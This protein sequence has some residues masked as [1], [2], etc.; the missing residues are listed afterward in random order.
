MVC[1]IK[2]LLLF[3]YL[4]L[5]A[6]LDK[7]EVPNIQNKP[8]GQKSQKHSI[9]DKNPLRSTTATSGHEKFGHEGELTKNTKVYISYSNGNML[10]N[11]GRL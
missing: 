6:N 3:S 4:D 11:W 10:T 8:K 5:Y 2:R 1:R 9:D 7:P